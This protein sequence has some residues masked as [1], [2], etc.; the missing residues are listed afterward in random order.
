[1]KSYSKLVVLSLS[2]LLLS[3][4]ADKTA[5]QYYASNGKAI[6]YAKMLKKLATADIVFF[7]ELHNN[8]MSHW[9]E[10][11]LAHDLAELKQ[12]KIVFGAEMFEADQQLIVDE[13]LKGMVSKKNFVAQARLWPN[14]STDYAPVLNLA[15]EKGIRFIATNV[16]RR[17]ASYVNKNGLEKLKEL[18]QEA[19]QYIAPLPVK[20]DPNVA[21]YA[22]MTKMMAGMPGARHGASHIAQAQA[23][24]DATMAHFILKNWK[25]GQLFFH[26]NGNYHSDNHEGIVWWIKQQKPELNILTISTMEQSKVDSISKEDLGLADYL[27][28]VDEDITK[29]Y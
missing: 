25:E 6:K 29:T 8:T 15:K 23:I 9:M 28:V 18:S 27:F 26:F 21:C 14:H 19:K 17:Y 7:G 5:Y 4:T 2:F 13:Y 11:E 20:Y 24:K 12:G 1:M 10:Y 22:K 16:P 3:M